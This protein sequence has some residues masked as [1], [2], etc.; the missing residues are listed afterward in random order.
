[1]RKTPI[2]FL[3]SWCTVL[4]V[5]SQT[6]VV[7]PRFGL[8]SA[9]KIAT[10]PDFTL[11]AIYKDRIAHPLPRA[12]D[13]TQSKFMPPMDWGIDGWACAHASATSYCYDF[14]AQV[15]QNIATTS[16]DPIYPYNYT[17]HF[18]NNG[19]QFDGGDGWMFVEAFDILKQTGCPTSTDM[20]GFGKSGSSGDI[21][22]LQLW[23]NGYDKYYNA[24]KLRVE[25]YYKIDMATAAADDVIKQLCYDRA[26]GS[27]QGTLLT[28]QV[29]SEMMPTA[30][31]NGRET[32][33]TLGGGGGHALTICGYDDNHKGGSWLVLTGWGDGFYWCPYSLLRATGA[34]Y[35][36]GTLMENNRYVMFCKVRR[37]YTPKF[38]FKISISHTQRNQLAI[39][40]GVASSQTATTPERTQ[41]YGEAF[42]Y[43]GGAIP[44]WGK[45]ANGKGGPTIEI[46]LD[47]TNFAPDLAGNAGT[48]FLQIVSK[49]GGTGKVNSLALMDYSGPTAKVIPCAETNKTITGTILMSVPWSSSQAGVNN[50]YNN[51]TQPN[52]T[53][54]ARYDHAAQVMYFTMP[55]G[56]QNSIVR[57]RN[58]RGRTVATPDAHHAATNLTI[59]WNLKN[60][61]GA[62]ISNGTYIASVAFKDRIGMNRELATKIV[63][64]E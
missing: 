60:E 48:F 13:N 31:V 10:I 35:G 47:L 9:A 59:P 58:L 56:A 24:M 34:W 20:G 11:P 15:T 19:L 21:G 49:G 54:T 44:M 32:I 52:N 42:N 25:E 23:C 62:R 8:M 28:F 4:S 64:A 2:I 53:L 5:Q 7:R 36:K 46:G 61:S 51:M 27:P 22:N 6:T 63:I 40:T 29:N 57:I 43:S 3:L 12:V 41:D 50:S 33:T 39:S 17:Y 38:A 1:M 55:T 45:A 18:M 30:L 14:E 37:N 16:V 26:D